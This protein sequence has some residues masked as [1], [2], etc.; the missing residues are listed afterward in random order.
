MR[1]KFGQYKDYYKILDVAENASDIEVKK[2][3]RKLA[4]EHHPDHNKNAPNSEEKFKQITEA[5]GVLIDPL[6]RKEY[7]R[8]R[9]DHLAGRINENSQFRYTQQ[10]I[11]EEML[12]KGFGKDV[13]EEL[14][15]E[16]SK[17]GFRSGNSF[18]QT[19]LMGGALGGIVRVLGMIPGPIGRV[20]QGLRIAHM[21]GTSLFALKKM[22]DA[23]SAGN[24]KN[25]P[26]NKNPD[27]LDSVKG[28]FNK[29][30][31][32]QNSLDYNLA[33]TIPPKE[34][35]EGT[36]KKI[37]YEIDGTPEQLMIRIPKKFPHGGKLRIKGKGHLKDQKRGDLILQVNVA[38]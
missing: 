30:I 6:K 20:G 32:S 35:L 28:V 29:G 18:F 21:V 10:D 12:R 37:S 4:L 34:A 27:I 1:T 22:H 11:F 25:Q 15:R 9:A 31:N 36:N 2:S 16:F 23:K 26:N 7:D 24:I 19:T 38:Y 8:F 17:S 33:M 14:N 3:Y 13:F 5:Y